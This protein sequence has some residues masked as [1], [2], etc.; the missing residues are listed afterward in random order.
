M[1]PVQ[2]CPDS[3]TVTEPMLNQHFNVNLDQNLNNTK[4]LGMIH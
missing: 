3:K 4:T 2:H 1:S